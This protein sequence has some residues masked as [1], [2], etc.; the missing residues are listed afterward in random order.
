MKRNLPGIILL[1]ATLSAMSAGCGTETRTISADDLQDKVYASWLG[2]MIGNIYG[3]VHENKYIDE[4]GPDDFPYGYDYADTWFGGR[5][6]DVM[7]RYDGAFSDDDTDFEYMY[8][9]LMEKYGPE[10]TYEQIAQAWKY[11]VRD[12]V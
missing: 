3:L 2:Q 4:P 10:P 1:S 12:F 9:I 6:T 7:R 8:L 11:H 5:M